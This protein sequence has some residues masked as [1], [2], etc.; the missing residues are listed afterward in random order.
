MEQMIP[1]PQQQP[2]IQFNPQ[3]QSQPPI[4]QMADWLLSN[5]TIP[6]NFKKEFYV[7][8]E[9]AVFGN[10]SELDIKRLML[11]FEEWTILKKWSTPDHQWG[12]LMTYEDMDNTQVDAADKTFTGM[13][14]P[15]IVIDMNLLFN[16]LRQL[17]F[18]QLTR[19]KGGFTLKEINS[20]RSILK[21]EQAEEPKKK[22]ISLF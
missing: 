2:Q 4:I 22:K 15:K 5:P 8:W 9:I 1:Q 7:L 21:N 11:D 20:V 10:Y 17:Y 19:G 12:N 6:L 14:A 18:I 13:G 16:I 3:Y